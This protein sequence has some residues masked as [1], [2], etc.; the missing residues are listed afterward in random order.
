[1]FECGPIPQQGS[2]LHDQEE[3]HLEPVER[4]TRGAG[5]R[6]SHRL[7]KGRPNVETISF[8]GDAYVDDER[9]LVLSGTARI[10]KLKSI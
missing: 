4:A 1:M 8:A 3:W 5:G 7:M 6:K 9:E 10:N 2:F